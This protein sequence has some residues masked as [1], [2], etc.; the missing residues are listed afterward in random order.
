[1]ET[2]IF[3]ALGLLILV[4]LLRCYS[5]WVVH[6]ANVTIHKTSVM[7]NHQTIKSLMSHIKTL[8]MERDDWK[9]AFEISDSHGWDE[10]AFAITVQG[11]KLLPVGWQKCLSNIS[12]ESQTPTPVA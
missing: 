7:I 3:I 11:V 12:E 8:E 6:K 1:M 5:A 9:K 10:T 2:M 4:E